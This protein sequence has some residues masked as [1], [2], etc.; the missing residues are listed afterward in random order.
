MLLHESFFAEHSCDE[1]FRMHNIQME[2]QSA[3]LGPNRL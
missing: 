1:D 3:I 2:L